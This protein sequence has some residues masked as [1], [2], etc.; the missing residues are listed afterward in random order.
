MFHARF[1]IS[2]LSLSA[3]KKELKQ[4]FESKYLAS[5]GSLF[6]KI[7]PCVG[8]E[9]TAK[10]FLAITIKSMVK[11]EIGKAYVSLT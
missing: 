11:T 1:C 10:R 9:N 2:C 4:D 5:N 8:G 3:L 6:Q 7:I